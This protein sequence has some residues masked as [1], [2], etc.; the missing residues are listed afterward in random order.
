MMSC[1]YSLSTN[2]LLSSSLF[3]ESFIFILC[4]QGHCLHE[5]CV[6]VPD[7][8][9]SQK[10][11]AGP[12]KFE[13]QSVVLTW[14]LRIEPGFSAKARSTK[15]LSDLFRPITFA[16]LFYLLFFYWSICYYSMIV[17]SLWTFKVGCHQLARMGSL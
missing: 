17:D 7:A 2:S 14:V 6:W 8:L 16:L 4:V 11:V 15:F 9:R 12:W 1:N 13:L 3:K 10:K 5:V